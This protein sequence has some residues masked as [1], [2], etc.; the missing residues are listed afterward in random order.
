VS[1]GTEMS[2][3]FWGVRGSIASPGK[4]T[5]RYG[6]NTSCVELRCGDRLVILDAGTGL[7]PLGQA[8]VV[9]GAPIDADL[10]CSHTHVDHVCG[11]PF[12]APCYT[13]GNHIRIWGGHAAARG[14]IRAVFRLMLT[15]PLFPDV[16]D[17]LAAT[18]EFKNFA[19]GDTLALG[20]GIA[21]RTASLNHP[22]GATGYRIEW[23]GKSLSYV[24]D[25]EHQ[26]DGPDAQLLALAASADT[27][28][29]DANYTDEDYAA[30]RGWG[31]STWQEGVKLAQ[32]AGV[33]RLVL[34]HHDPARSDDMLDKIADAASRAMPGTLVA[35]EG[36]VLTL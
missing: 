19:A 17:E 26:S 24:T 6:A 28:I 15:P 8:L 21:V 11:F 18:V 30:H 27:M 16:M 20:A 33:R 3:R 32:R 31:H 34:F 36:L 10:L 9:S 14:D 12:F 22:G 13:A 25:I 5:V 2:A 4:E 23:N 35:R 1:N 7:R 29:Y